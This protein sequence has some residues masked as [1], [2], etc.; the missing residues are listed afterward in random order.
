MKS[1]I[2]TPK[3]KTVDE[4]IAIASPELKEYL[5]RLRAAIRQAAPEADEVISY[6]MPAY[7]QNGIVVYFGG[8]AKHVSLFPGADAIEV[9]K[10]ELADYKTSK[11]TIRFALDRPL[12]IA[13]IKKI[14][15]LR[16]KEN[17][18]KQKTKAKKAS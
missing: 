14:V 15:K 7:K 9:F 6:Q 16:V 1:E 10:D 11:G 13:L 2:N 12:P 17:L 3:P 18:A 8:F 5:V 4:Y